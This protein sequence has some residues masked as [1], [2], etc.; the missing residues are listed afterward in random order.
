VVGLDFVEIIQVVVKIIDIVGIHDLC[1][2]V[3]VDVRDETF[4]Q[5]I[6]NN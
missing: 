5:C 3:L 2:V 1:I 4:S 6:Q